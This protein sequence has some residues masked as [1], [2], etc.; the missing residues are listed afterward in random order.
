[1]LV[2][3]LCKAASRFFFTLIDAPFSKRNIPSRQAVPVLNIPVVKPPISST[4][5]IKVL[6]NTPINIGAIMRTPGIF[7]ISLKK[8]F[9]PSFFSPLFFGYWI[10]DMFYVIIISFTFLFA[11][12]QIQI[13]IIHILYSSLTCSI[14]FSMQVKNDFRL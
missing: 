6:L 12:P 7:C 5:R 2:R 13:K 4:P 1:M 10:L 8:L 9:S 14:I 11:N 3:T